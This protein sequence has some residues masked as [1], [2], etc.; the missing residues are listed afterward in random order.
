MQYRNEEL[1]VVLVLTGSPE[2]S[3][4]LCSIQRLPVA[5]FSYSVF[6]FIQNLSNTCCH[7]NLFTPTATFFAPFSK[8]TLWLFDLNHIILEN[9]LVQSPWFKWFQQVYI[10]TQCFTSISCRELGRWYFGGKVHFPAYSTKKKK[11]YHRDCKYGKIWSPEP[12]LC[13]CSL[14]GKEKEDNEG[15][16]FQ[17]PQGNNW[18]KVTETYRFTTAMLNH[19]S[20]VMRFTWREWKANG[21]K[22]SITTRQR[23]C[24]GFSPLWKL[25]SSHSS[26]KPC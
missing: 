21:A 3:L 7:C 11:S 8:G 4:K 10:A 22:G 12:H 1:W 26:S 19:C 24:P 17:F 13:T 14:K 18:R 20:S 2:R 23:K 9:L 5:F 16:E 6:I 15:Q 25:C